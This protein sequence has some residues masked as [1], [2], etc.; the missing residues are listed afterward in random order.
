MRTLFAALF[1]FAVTTLARCENKDDFEA[2]LE[3]CLDYK[4]QGNLATIS[5]VQQKSAIES[6]KDAKRLACAKIEV[7]IAEREKAQDTIEQILSMHNLAGALL[8]ATNLRQEVNVDATKLSQEAKLLEGVTTEIS[9]KNSAIFQR[10]AKRV[11]VSKLNFQTW[12]S[13]WVNAHRASPESPVS[14]LISL[15]KSPKLSELTRRKLESYFQRLPRF[16]FGTIEPSRQPL[17]RLQQ[18]ISAVEEALER[19]NRFYTSVFR[20][21][22]ANTISTSLEPALLKHAAKTYYLKSRSMQPGRELAATSVSALAA[23]ACYS[24]R[25]ELENTLAW[26]EAVSS[27]APTLLKP[28]VSRLEGEDKQRLRK[29]LKAIGEC[30][31]PHYFALLNQSIDRS[32]QLT[33]ASNI[34]KAKQLLSEANS[35][36]N[37]ILGLS[38]ETVARNSIIVQINSEKIWRDLMLAEIACQARGM[39]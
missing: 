38:P 28:E 12:T 2:A 11:E 24:A 15:S 37:A 3:R 25:Y 20:K 17:L 30:D 1:L 8:P 29:S 5:A 13:M 21:S 26:I 35:N 27:S 9:Q 33:C 32:L 39:Q 14:K 10:L 36:W 7:L 4:E 19:R 6:N 23:G 16:L 18:T 34:G 31:K 22:V